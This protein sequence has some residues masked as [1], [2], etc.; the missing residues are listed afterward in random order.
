MK[1]M[2]NKLLAMAIACVMLFMVG[3]GPNITGVALTLPEKM[4]KGSTAVAAAEYTYDG[5]TPAQDKAEE[6]ISELGITYSSS[7][8]NVVTVDENGNLTAVA[9][10]TAEITLTSENGKITASGTVEVVISPTEISVP[11]T[12]T[13]F[14]GHD[15]GTPLETTVVPEDATGVVME[16]ASS[17]ENIVTVDETGCI[18]AL[19]AGEADVT[20]T[21]TDTELTGVCHV[22]VQP[23]IETLKMST[24]SATLKTGASKTLSLV[25]TPKEI[26]TSSATWASS[27]E[28]I[29]TV[30]AEGTVTAVAEGKA[31]ITAMLDGQE[32]TCEITV[33]NKTSANKNES[34]ASDSSTAGG[35]DATSNSGTSSA[36]STAYGAVP[37]SVATG[38]QE[39]FG[40]DSSDSAFSATLENINAYRAAVGVAP[41]SIDSGL[42]AIADQRCRDMIIA[43]VMSHD[44]H[45]TP[46]I[47]GQNYNSAQ[48]V[49]DAWAASPDHYAAMT[50]ANYTICGIGCGFYENG[51]TY[52]CV[53]FG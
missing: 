18:T 43:G 30:D 21:I 17:D 47:C 11:E 25:T 26:D 23:A 7:D 44:G 12:L 1:K 5:D 8:T 50:N 39:W 16:Y 40:I 45:Q 34:S 20:V 15:E 46:E 4:E 2:R 51:A 52:W 3:C 49:V 14:L 41:L 53:T 27:D 22:V 36:T 38:T 9:P 28:S 24:G 19:A 13:V 42:T 32:V 37:F 31:T 35:N 6:L 10:G 48:S 29:A 33:S